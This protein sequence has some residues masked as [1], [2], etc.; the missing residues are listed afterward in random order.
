[1]FHEACELVPAKM[2]GDTRVLKAESMLLHASAT[3]KRISK[4]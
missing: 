3:L 1:M 4:T 2:N